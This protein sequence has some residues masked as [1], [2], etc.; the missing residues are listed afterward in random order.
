MAKQ[1]PRQ[2]QTR[3]PQRPQGDQSRPPNQL[4]KRD[5]KFGSIKDFLVKA[6]KQIAIAAPKHMTADRLIRIALSATSRNPLLLECTP[7]SLTLALINASET[8]L[9]PNG[10]VA[11]LIPRFNFNKT[12]ERKVYEAQFMPDYKGYIQLAYRSGLVKTFDCVPVFKKDRFD[13]SLGTKRFINHVPTDDE[14]P[15]ELVYSYATCELAGG[16]VEFRV[17]NRR[18]VM[19]RKASSAA[20]DSGPWSTFEPAMWAKSAGRDLYKF[21]PSSA[22]MVRAAM[23]DDAFEMGRRQI[24]EA[25]MAGMLDLSFV[26]LTE[27]EVGGAAVGETIGAELVEPE[28]DKS[29]KL[30]DKLKGKND[31]AAAIKQMREEFALATTLEQAKEVYDHQ[32]GPDGWAPTEELMAKSRELWEI[33]KAELKGG[34]GNLPLG[35]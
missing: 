16:G 4:A 24:P 13:F 21:V 19:K 12:L 11:H 1:Q 27:D 34:Q 28:P 25:A 26:G 5:E 35:D 30:A 32:A 6:Q 15:G 2:Q 18:E 23:V 33:R 17:L 8:G 10:W 14:D 9:E 29:T 22:E 31:E 7:Q 3:P 20:K